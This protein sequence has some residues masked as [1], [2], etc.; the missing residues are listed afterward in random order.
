MGNCRTTAYS[1]K[2]SEEVRSM[3]RNLVTVWLDYRKAFDS[4]PHSWL[5]HTLKLVKLPNH[6][7]TAI[8]N[9]T[10]S[11]YTKLNLNGKDDSIVSNVIKIIRGIH[12]G[13]SLSVILFVLTLNPLFH[14]LRSTKGYAYGKNR[15]H[16]HTH[17]FFVD[18]LKLYATDMN[19]VKRELEIITTFSKDSGMKFGEDKCAFLHI[20]K[21]IIKKSSPININH[22]T[23][24]PT[25]DEDSY[26]HLG[27]DENITYNGPLNKEK[28]S[29]EYLN[30]VRKIWAS[31]L[32]DFNKIIAHNNFAVP[33]IT[34]TIEI[35]NWTIDKIRQIDISTRK[36]LS[37]TGRFHLNSDVDR[38]YMTRVKGGSGLRSIR[39]LYESRI[40][41]LRQHLLRNANRNEI[42]GYVSEYE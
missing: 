36:L 8:K 10:E 26:K 11:W 4:I 31:E 40:I 7:L 28:V 2:H 12:Q 9:L 38:M 17:N 15:Q 39:T 27:I 19:M 29:E 33:I 20:E 16:Q 24:Q 6:L 14:L 32:S 37:M 21:E 41:S 18:D 35:I 42:L 13:D 3:R 30:R 5:L 34:P 22:I 25:A 23:I 1:R